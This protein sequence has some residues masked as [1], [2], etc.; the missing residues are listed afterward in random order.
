MPSF[1]SFSFFFP[2]STFTGLFPT[3]NSTL[4]K[5]SSKALDSSLPA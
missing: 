1:F 5:L 2:T 3:S 4:S